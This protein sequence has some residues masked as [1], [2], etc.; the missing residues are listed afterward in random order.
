MV[1]LS[2]MDSK[3]ERRQ[4]FLQSWNGGRPQFSGRRSSRE[5]IT[6]SAAVKR[7]DCFGRDGTE[8]TSIPAALPAVTPILGKPKNKSTYKPHN[9]ARRSYIGNL[10][11]LV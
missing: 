8:T 4:R 1:F 10:I 11:L 2:E 6:S 9:V 3:V 5:L 7:W